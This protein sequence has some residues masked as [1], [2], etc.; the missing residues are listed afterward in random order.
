MGLIGCFAIP[1]K[2]Q[3]RKDYFNM[4]LVELAPGG[5]LNPFSLRD[6]ICRHK[7]CFDWRIPHVFGR[8]GIPSCN[9]VKLSSTVRLLVGRHL[10]VLL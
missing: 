6:A 7:L 1:D 5:G 3:I 10:A 2:R 9:I 4:K 8:H